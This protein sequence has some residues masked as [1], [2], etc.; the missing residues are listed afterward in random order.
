MQN[1]TIDRDKYIGGSDIPIIM[2][3]SPF[4]KRFD[5]L[6]EKAGLEVNDFHGN[7]YTEY[8]NVLEPKIRD[9]I[10]NQKICKKAFKE[11]KEIIGDIRIHTDGFNGE[12]VLE[13]KTTSQIHE[14][15]DDYLVYLVQ[16]IFYMH[17]KKV[18]K[19]LLAVYERPNDFDEEFDEKRLQLFFIDLD[20]YLD[21]LDKILK[22]VDKFRVD[23]EKVKANPFITEEELLSN[24]LKELTELFLANKKR[25]EEL[26]KENSKIIEKLEPLFE[27]EGIKSLDTKNKQVTFVKGTLPKVSKVK[28]FNLDKFEK[29]NE[30]VFKKYNEEVISYTFNEEKFK[31]EENE[32]YEKYSEEKEVTSKGKASSLRVTDIKKKVEGE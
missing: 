26:E 32:L 30:D 2:G 15:V 4:R 22:A 28:T 3:I 21:L 31:E 29:E 9:Y 6:L 18:K 1:V 27:Q 23:L 7:S 17:H 19:G 12:V 24:N 20:N 8:G 5:L 11:D 10:N 13:V 14:N 16:L 25:M